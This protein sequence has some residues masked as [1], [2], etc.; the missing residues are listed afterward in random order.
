MVER[1]RELFYTYCLS[2]MGVPDML[3]SVAPLCRSF[4]EAEKLCVDSWL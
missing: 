2:T 3:E 1:C 4:E